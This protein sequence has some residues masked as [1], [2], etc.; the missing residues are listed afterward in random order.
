MK[1]VEASQVDEIVSVSSWGTV[2]AVGDDRR[3]RQDPWASGTSS[4][5]ELLRN[6]TSYDSTQTY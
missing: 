4:S 1:P 5:R 6:A 2:A 3:R